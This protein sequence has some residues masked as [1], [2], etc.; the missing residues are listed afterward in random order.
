MEQITHAVSLNFGRV[1]E[2]Q[3]LWLESLDALLHT[4]LSPDAAEEAGQSS[5]IGVPLKVPADVQKVRREQQPGGR[6]VEG[7]IFLA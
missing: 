1:F 5:T 4:A 2:T 3:M 7:K 6:S